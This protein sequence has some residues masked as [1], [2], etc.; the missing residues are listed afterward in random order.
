MLGLG[1]VAHTCNPSTLGD[2]SGQITRTQYSIAPEDAA[3]RQLRAAL[4]TDP[5]STLILGFPASRMSLA[6]GH[7]GEERG[8]TEVD[9]ECFMA[10]LYVSTLICLT[11]FR[12][13]ELGNSAQLPREKNKAYW[14]L[15]QWLMPII[16]ALWETEAGGSLEEFET[17]LANMVKSCLY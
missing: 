11:P 17:G 15:A 6:S 7:S 10:T 13:R 1:T 2:R 14:G 16:P 12:Q 5:A 3:T 4:D 9:V 8:K